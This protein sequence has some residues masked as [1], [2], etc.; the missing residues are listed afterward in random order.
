M[1]ITSCFKIGIVCTQ[2]KF[3]SFIFSS[4]MYIVSILWSSIDVKLNERLSFPLAKQYL[5]FHTQFPS[6]SHTHRNASF[7]HLPNTLDVKFQC[8]PF[9]IHVTGWR[10]KRENGSISWTSHLPSQFALI[11]YRADIQA[12]YNV[13]VKGTYFETSW[14]QIPALPLISYMT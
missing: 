2:R 4:Y 1:H 11:V 10:P 8:P 6:V 3:L 14:A 9:R 13:V 7:I 12:V 5:K